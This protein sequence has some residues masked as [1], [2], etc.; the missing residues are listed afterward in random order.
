MEK[1]T[2]SQYGWIVCIILILALLMG[3]AAP[4]ASYIKAAVMD[5]TN[6]VI[7]KGNEA[8]DY[9]GD[10][11]MVDSN[12]PGGGS[13]GVQGTAGLFDENGIILKTWEQLIKDGSVTVENGDTLTAMSIQEGDRLV[14]PGTITTAGSDAVLFGEYKPQGFKVLEFQNGLTNVSRFFAK[15]TTSITTIIF[16]DSVT[17][18]GQGSFDNYEVLIQYKGVDY[19]ISATILDAMNKFNELPEAENNNAVTMK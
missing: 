6:A 7:E 16:P 17:S 3:M 1:N 15:G 9:I 11:G 4:F 5:S 8:I 12:T 14:V 19:A 18:F 2:I 10:H 13:G